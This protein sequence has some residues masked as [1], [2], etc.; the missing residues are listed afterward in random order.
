MET[1]TECPVCGA[2][3]FKPFL[4]C[5]DYLV[6]Q[7]KFAIQQCETCDFRLT[8][9]RPDANSIGSYYKSEDYVSHNDEGKGLINT[10]YRIVRNYTLRSKLNLINKLNGGEGRILDVGC[11][12]GAFLENCKTAGW[13]V[14]G[15]EPDSDA[16]DIAQKKL[17]IEVK[18]NLEA[19]KGE[20]PFDIISL[21]HVLEHV[22]N[23]NE[24]IPQLYQLLSSK[25][26]LL[27]AVP[28]SDSYDAHYFK[29]YWAAYDV[30]RHLHHFTPSTIK[31][32]F[33]KHGFVLTDQ[34]PMVFDAFYIAMLS[35]RYK[36]G[37]ADYLKSIQIGL[38]SNAEAKRTGNSS[39]LIY[40]LKKA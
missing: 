22:S 34:K 5:Q 8:N 37:K 30:P 23:L 24:V 14:M 26:T 36:S 15:M 11:G 4:V 10:A 40:I 7:Q 13:N 28:N 21:W 27:I 16:R 35:T 32:L 17:E 3:R 9:P 12:T 38:S 29:E 19:I 25:G 1:I 6:S 2:N 20:E 18:P 31:P 39:S 33:Q